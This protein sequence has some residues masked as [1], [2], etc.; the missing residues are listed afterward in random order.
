MR[1]S[2]R[3]AIATIAIAV[4]TGCAT[5][6]TG[7]Q[8]Q[9]L[10]GYQAKGLAIEE[11]NPGA[12]AALGLL[13]GG[14]SFYVREYGAGIVNLLFWPVSILWDPVSGYQGAQSINY[15]ATK[16]TLQRKKNKAVSQLEDKLMMETISKQQFISKKRQIENKYDAY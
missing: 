7:G 2:I 9:E 12:A 6:L 14:G 8:K 15:Y 1:A 11:K 4:I 10:R 13:P 3:L 5:P 16:Q